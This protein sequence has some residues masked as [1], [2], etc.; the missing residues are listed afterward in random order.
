MPVLPIV[1]R[2][3]RFPNARVLLAL[4]VLAVSGCASTSEAP[5]PKASDG[6]GSFGEA[7]GAVGGAALPIF[8]GLFADETFPV[9]RIAISKVIP[10]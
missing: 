1:S 3:H 7:A 2:Q 4:L 9:V 8:F 10:A 5:E 6:K